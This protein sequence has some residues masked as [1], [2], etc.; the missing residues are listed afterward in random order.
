MV[1]GTG[2]WVSRRSFHVDVL[3]LSLL[4]S[5]FEETYRA[6]L[7]PSVGMV[8]DELF[9]S[10]IWLFEGRCV[11]TRKK[12]GQQSSPLASGRRGR[13][14][15]LGNM[16][17]RTQGNLLFIFICLLFTHHFNLFD[18]CSLLILKIFF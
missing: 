2:S 14:P 13:K 11:L 9:L 16:W 3:E 1:V 10:N 8:R 4:V 15:S 17:N 6:D 5:L 7:P 18:D 12:Q